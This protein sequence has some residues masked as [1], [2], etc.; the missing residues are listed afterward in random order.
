MRRVVGE[1]ER[2][3]HRLLDPLMRDPP[4]AGFLGHA[5]PAGV[6]LGDDVR[7]G[8]AN[9]GGR[10]AGDSVVRASHAASIVDC[11]DI[12]CPGQKR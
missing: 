2:E 10:C 6:E 11:S 4:A 9:V 7:D 12:G 3:Q 1:P 8:V 5:Q